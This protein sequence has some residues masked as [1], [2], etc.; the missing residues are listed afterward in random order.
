MY[1]LKLFILMLVLLSEIAYG[2]VYKWRDGNGNVHYSNSPPEKERSEKIDIKPPPVQS[3]DSLEDLMGEKET[4]LFVVPHGYI[5]G[6]QASLGGQSIYELVPSGE[7]VEDWS[8]MIT[9]FSQDGG[10]GIDL[11]G[12]YDDSRSRMKL[13][14]KEESESELIDMEEHEGFKDAL[15]Y[16]ACPELESVGSVAV[17]SGKPE[18]VLSRAI[19]GRGN[20]FLISKMWRFEPSQE[21]LDE[22]EKNLKAASICNEKLSEIPCSEKSPFTS[23]AGMGGLSHVSRK[24]I[25]NSSLSFRELG[26]F[27]PNTSSK[28]LETIGSGYL[29]KAD[30]MAFS[31][32]ISLKARRGLPYGAYLEARFDNPDEPDKPF[33]VGISRRGAQRK[34]TI[35]SPEFRNLRC[36]NYQV[37]ISVYRG[38]SKS[39]LLGKHRQMI[40]SRINV[41]RIKKAEDYLIAGIKGGNCS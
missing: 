11:E 35:M 5:M 10:G 14:C 34:M 7:S 33:V 2:A 8:E 32:S 23:K 16:L 24:H 26:P 20:F 36:R 15:W 31:F 21:Q 22:W 17:L 25:D 4:L 37:L 29:I 13:G 9:V 27:P 30:R 1:K 12:Y 18:Y 41:D 19:K 39:D 40:Q 38:K 28:Y 6:Y 3:E